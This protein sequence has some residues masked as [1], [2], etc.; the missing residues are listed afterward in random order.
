MS[1]DFHYYF[2]LYRLPT[3]LPILQKKMANIEESFF[4]RKKMSVFKA[5][6]SQM[7]CKQGLGFYFCLKN[8]NVQ[9]QIWQRFTATKL[10][11]I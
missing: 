4:D 2:F 6:D 7:E 11:V 10:Y 9:N 5:K 8:R 1:C 3:Y